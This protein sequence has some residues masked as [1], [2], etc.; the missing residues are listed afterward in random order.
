MEQ[1]EAQRRQWPAVRLRMRAIISTTM[2]IGWVV[3]AVS[4]LIPYFF[5]PRGQGSEEAVL[6]LTRSGWMS[7]H[8]WTS[9]G[10]VVFTLA[11]VLLNRRGVSRAV[12]VVSGAERRVVPGRE[13]PAK[14]WRRRSVAWG[15]VVVS[16]ALL[17]GGGLA[18]AADRDPVG[19]GEGSAGGG[20]RQWERVVDDLEAD[21]D[22]VPIPGAEEGTRRG[23]GGRNR[24]SAVS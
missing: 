14:P 17:V 19:A 20:G 5:V 10:M 8:L 3:A 23:G 11:H 21:S 18:F 12:K 24:R 7:L 15:T 22:G 2:V 6:G 16:L 4:G 1:T 13:G 9:I